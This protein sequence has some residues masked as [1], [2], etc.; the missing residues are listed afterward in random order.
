MKSKGIILSLIML[1]IVF[2]STTFVFYNKADVYE[3]GMDSGIQAALRDTALFFENESYDMDYVEPLY[4]LSGY[5]EM[6]YSYMQMTSNSAIYSVA[7]VLKKFAQPDTY[8]ELTAEQRVKTA[9]YL[10][11][12]ADGELVDFEKELLP[13]LNELTY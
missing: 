7:K 5:A 3:A 11:Q 9:Q 12:L 8:M 6:Q 10:R 2:V 13:F 4:R 1:T